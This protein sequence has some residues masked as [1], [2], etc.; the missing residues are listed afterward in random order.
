MGDDD[1]EEEE[2][3]PLMGEYVYYMNADN[4]RVIGTMTS[5]RRR[6]DATVEHPFEY[7]VDDTWVVEIYEC[8]ECNY[9]AGQ[10]ITFPDGKTRTIKS[11]DEDEE[12][13]EFEVDEDGKTVVKSFDDLDELRDAADD[14][15]LEMGEEIH[16][17]KTEEG[18]D[19][20]AVYVYHGKR[21]RAVRDPYIAPKK[22]KTNPDGWV[23]LKDDTPPT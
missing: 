5:K 11:V 14:A 21:V 15:A 2:D 10:Q 22:S 12:L 1:D 20:E 23:G 4:R 3:D 13:V 9:A 17:K 18:F 8:E 19:T 7:L 6:K 16:A